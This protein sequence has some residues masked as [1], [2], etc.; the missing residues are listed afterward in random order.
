M[1]SFC[2]ING[3]TNHMKYISFLTPH[4]TISLNGWS[5]QINNINSF[6]IRVY[7]TMNLEFQIDCRQSYRLIVILFYYF[8]YTE[9]IIKMET[10][11]REYRKR[12]E[13]DGHIKVKI[14]NKIR[15][16]FSI[17]NSN[18]K[19]RRKTLKISIRDIFFLVF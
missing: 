9:P 5:N 16:M 13:L 12:E 17:F 19:K 7:F 10:D 8:S 3:L 1:S 11:G 15:K 4:D 18:K 2:P 6:K 14:I